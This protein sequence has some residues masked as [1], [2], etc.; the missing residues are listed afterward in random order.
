MA[1]DGACKKGGKGDK[2][3]RSVRGVYEVGHRQQ[4][5]LPKS[6]RRV[7]HHVTTFN[8]EHHDRQNVKRE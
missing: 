8:H 5:F 2:Q 7:V 4:S 1:V 3:D 6:Q